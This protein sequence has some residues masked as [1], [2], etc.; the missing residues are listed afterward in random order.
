MPV[1]TDEQNRRWFREKN[2]RFFPGQEFSLEIDE[3]LYENRSNYQN[4]LV[5]KR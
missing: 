4:I 1:Y 5:F 2:D 3:I